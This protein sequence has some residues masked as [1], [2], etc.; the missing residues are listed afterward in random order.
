MRVN[1]VK[2]MLRPSDF[3]HI[4]EHESWF[5]D[6]AQ[7]GLHLKKV[8]IQFVKFTKGEPKQIKYRI[9]VSQGNKI[10]SEQKEMYSQSGWDYVTSYG[11]FN[12]FS[13]PVELNAPE[14]HTDPAEQAYTLNHLNKKITKNA[15]LVAVAVAVMI[16][17]IVAFWFRDSAHYLALVEG[18]I[19]QQATLIII[20]LYVVYTSV[21]PAISLRALQKTLSAGK[22]INHS[23]PWKRQHKAKLIVASFYIVLAIFASIHPF[24]QLTMGYT[25]TMPVAS[26]DLPIV[27]LADVEQ[28]TALVRKSSL[29]IRDNVDWANRYSYDWSLFA[30]LQYQ[31][32]EQ[33]VVP[34]EM[35]K[36][37][38]GAYSPSIHTWVYKLNFPDM[39]EGVLSDLIKR[40]GMKY[41]GGE[42]LEIENPYFDKLIVH[43]GDSFK[44]IFAYKGKGV[45]YIRYFGYAD[46][47]SII[48]ATVEKI[49]LISD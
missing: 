6:M 2:N 13:S 1:K 3:W 22:P 20:E 45:V 47:D 42:F 43:E 25:K 18:I 29:H 5:S 32:D 48:G 14:L 27:I 11:V 26:T 21:Q 34:N 16:V 17:M 4:G 9:D 31:T 8:G 24:M 35:W 33:G 36:D 23:A 41:E 19:I 39:H 30:P 38:S 49:N 15:I 28:N 10:T 37:G 40:Y 46:I 7:E 12:V 44:E